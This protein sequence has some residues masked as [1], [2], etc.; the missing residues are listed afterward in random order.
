MRK[1]ITMGII[2]TLALGL[3]GCIEANPPETV[4][5]DPIVVEEPTVV[6]TK[7]ED[8]EDYAYSRATGELTAVE[9]KR[10]PPALKFFKSLRSSVILYSGTT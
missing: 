3:S 6:E 4:T 7:I 1:M 8:T 5:E 2:A 10:T 9:Y